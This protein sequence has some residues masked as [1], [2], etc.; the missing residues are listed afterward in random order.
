MRV[1]AALICH[2]RFL[3][4]LASGTISSRP[5]HH[6]ITLPITCPLIA[7]IR[8]LPPH[9]IG[10]VIRHIARF[11]N[12]NRP[13]LL[14]IL[15]ARFNGRAFQCARKMQITDTYSNDPFACHTIVYFNTFSFFSFFYRL[16]LFFYKL[17]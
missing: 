4:T 6:S 2:A 10:C 11:T 5:P 17:L 1:V 3:R 8:L 12:P 15:S 7:S 16:I 9:F 14:D 13:I